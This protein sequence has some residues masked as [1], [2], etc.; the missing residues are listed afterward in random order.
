VLEVANDNWPLQVLRLP[1]GAG[2]VEESELLV[3]L[4]ELGINGRFSNAIVP[5]QR[6]LLIVDIAAA[7]QA[8]W[9]IQAKSDCRL[10]GAAATV[11]ARVMP[12]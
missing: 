8:L 11:G 6:S 7:V 12:A 9:W 1:L 10:H 5:V 4:H 3:R 2:K